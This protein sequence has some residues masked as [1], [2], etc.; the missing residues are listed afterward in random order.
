MAP[1]PLRFQCTGCGRCCT[2]RGEWYIAASRV[3]QQRIQRFLNVSWTW[4]R[5]RYVTVYEDGTESLRWEQDRCVF[6]D[7][8]RRCRIY[9]VRPAQCR[10]YPFWPDVVASVATWRAEGKR[11]EGIGRGAVI[12]IAEVLRRLRRQQKPVV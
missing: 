4:F 2:G 7:R 5:R 3:E 9:P 6:L 1:A 10:D 8:E 12:P 11:C